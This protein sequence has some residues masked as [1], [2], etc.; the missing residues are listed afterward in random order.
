MD[1]KN[2][3]LGIICIAGGLYF[4]FTQQ[5]QLSEQQRQQA[6]EQANEELAALE[7]E[8]TGTTPADAVIAPVNGAGSGD[9]V[10]DLIAQDVT[11]TLEVVEA[12]EAIEAEP[13]TVQLAN[14]FIEVDFTTA[15]GAIREVAFLQ[16]KRGE[17]DDYI[18]NEDGFLPAL[19]LSIAK[20]TGETVE[21]KN[22]FMIE[23]QSENA[24]TFAFKTGSGLTIRRSYELAASGS[25]A[26]PYVIKHST[27]FAN[28]SA[29]PVPLKELYLNLGTARAI[30]EKAQPNFLNVGYYNGDDSKFIAINKLTGSSGFLGIGASEPRQRIEK[31]NVNAQWTS[32][33][34]Q[35][36]AAVLSS[37]AVATDVLIDQVPTAA[38][39]DGKKARAGITGSA[40]YEFGTIAPGTAQTINF[41]YY[42][43]PKE[44]KRLQAL[45]NYQDKVMQFGFLSFISKLLLSFM[46]FIHGIVP[47]WGWSIIIM[48]ICIKGVFWPLTAQASKSQKRMAKI[49]GPMAE[50]KEKYADNPQKMQQETLK[51][52]RE[53][54]V[55]PVAGCLP[56][57]IQ[58]PIFLGLFY[59]LR[60]ASELRHEPFL[61][62]QDLS[63]PDTMF[64]VV[65]FPINILPIIM[66]VTMFLQMSMMPVSPTADPMQQKIFKFL[67]FVF[68]IFLYNFSSGL[69]LY[70][71][72]QNILTI[73]QQKITNAMPD[74]PFQPAAATAAPAAKGKGGAPRT[75]SK[76]KK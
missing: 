62:V 45:G 47:S 25:D 15:G 75:K 42:V 24:I 68:L 23:S 39:E 64:E 55:N 50:L 72:M 13:T 1:K 54:R 20:A 16:T 48:T 3:I 32:V 53:H 4:M 9:A 52:F 70:W 33:K 73:I 61:W 58:M 66:G 71:T 8:T 17:R 10:I 49:Q 22:N 11:E 36:F 51:L 19:S 31:G 65:G 63:M 6:L 29:A 67:P 26:E 40:G 60:T 14:E 28:T 59:M 76:K 18:F 38:R 74:E 37:D 35:F 46:Y 12:S 34:N 41:E 57:F 30:N 44:F 43:G 21:L 5:A 56:L 2:T 27:S 69:V 7:S